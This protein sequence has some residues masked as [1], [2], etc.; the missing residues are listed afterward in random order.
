VEL[1]KWNVREYKLE[2]AQGDAA[3]ILYRPITHGWRTRH[4]ELSLSLQ[5][6]VGDL[7]R[8]SDGQEDS[9]S[10]EDIATVV[11]SQQEANEA[12]ARFRAEL[13][14]ELVV[15]S[16]DLTINGEN[17]SRDDLVEALMMLED[18]SVDLCAH[19][20]SEGSVGDDEGKD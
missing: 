11:A 20:V 13:I 8:A 14:S 10:E 3:F 16:R 2:D 15:G 4:L 17:P 9:M 1:N 7:S 6:M 18:L 12:L 5:R 19:I